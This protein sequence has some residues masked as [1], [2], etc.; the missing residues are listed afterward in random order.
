MARQHYINIRNRNRRYIWLEKFKNERKFCLLNHAIKISTKHFQNL[1]FTLSK[2]VKT[3]ISFRRHYITVSCDWNLLEFLRCKVWHAKF[4][5]WS[6]NRKSE[7]FLGSF[8]KFMWCSHP[9]IRK[10]VRK[11]PEFL[12]KIRIGWLQILFYLPV[13]KAKIRP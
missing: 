4:C 7:K 10:F 11:K 13:P 8:R 12:I 5:Y 6:A 2:F 1:R 3:I 9:Q